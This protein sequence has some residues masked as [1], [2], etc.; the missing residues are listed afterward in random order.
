MKSP[1]SITQITPSRF[2]TQCNLSSVLYSICIQH[3]DSLKKEDPNNPDL[4]HFITESIHSICQNLAK[5][6][7]NDFTDV[8]YWNAIQNDSSI[9]K[10][11][12]ESYRPKPQ[13]PIG[14]TNVES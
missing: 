2:I 7:N 5:I 10:Q 14:K 9:I 3:H 8:D 6:V 13:E 11:I 1:K 12:L 4:P